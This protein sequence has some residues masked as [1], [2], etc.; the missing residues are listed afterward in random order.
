MGWIN[1]RFIP[2][3]NGNLI[4]L[5]SIK[6]IEKED[7]YNHVIKYSFNASDYS[8]TSEEFPTPEERDTRFEEVKKLIF[9]LQ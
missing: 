4:N 2:L 7:K 3:N 1:M 6:S 8:Y 9:S 5:D